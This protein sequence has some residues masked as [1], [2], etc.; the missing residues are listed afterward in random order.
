MPS[1]PGL[2][3]EVASSRA[4]SATRG[5]TVGQGHQSS[6]GIGVELRPEGGQSP[7][8]VGHRGTDDQLY[9]PIVQRVQREHAA[10]G[11]KGRYHL[12]GRILGGGADEYNGAV[13]HVGE[14]GV[15]LC[16]VEAVDLVHEQDGALGVH[17]QAFPGL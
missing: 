2:V 14:H 8:P 10:P 15:L 12:E 11:Q 5:V 13:L 16:L 4:L 7:F 6:Q 3:A 9:L 17:A 1:P